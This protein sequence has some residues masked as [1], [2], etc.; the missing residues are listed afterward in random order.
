MKRSLK[1]QNF[2][3]VLVSLVVIIVMSIG[4]LYQAIQPPKMTVPQ[5]TDFVLAN[6]T[7]WNPGS[8]ITPDQTLH[9]S[10]GIISKIEASPINGMNVICDGCFAMP[11]LIDAHVHTPPSIAVGNRELFSLLY[12]QYGVTSVRDLGQFDDD[13][14]DL[15]DRLEQGAL[16]GPRMYACGRILDGE[17]IGPPGAILVKTFQDGQRAVSELADQNVD[18]VKVY[19]NLSPEAFKGVSEM[20]NQL[21]LPLVGHTPNAMSFDNIQNFESQHYTGIPYLTKPAPTGFAYKSRDLINMSQGDV[22]AVLDV[23][24]DNNISF[25]PTNANLES[26]L[27]VSDKERFPPSEGFKHMP[28]FWE[29]AWPSIVSAPETDIEIQTEID[30]RPYALSFI[31]QA[32]ERDIDVL[33]GTDVV[34][35]YVIPGEAMH[36]QLAIIA[37]ALGSTEAALESATRI[38]GEHIDPD[39][40]GG[41][42]IG[43]YADMLLFKTDPRGDLEA[44]K[45]WDFAIIGGRLYARADVDA[46]V[47]AL[48][49]HFK[50]TLYSFVMN[51]AYGFLAGDYEASNVSKH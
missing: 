48:D 17:P 28:E 19:G 42:K 1:R 9:I 20:A 49:K 51:T 3:I 7:L 41:I 6:L 4:A 33:I 37:E 12:L 10:N 13:L 27:T 21:S 50:G 25:L 5:R 18:C 11:G 45:N 23:M 24:S 22:D 44:V 32:H 15:I 29:I 47:N 43:A 31:R 35:P 46:A 34:M 36:Q 30:A 16:A 14:P 39:K 26:R 38:N 40:I 2:L 8:D